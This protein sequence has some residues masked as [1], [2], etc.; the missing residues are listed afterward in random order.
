MADGETT[1]PCTSGEV[2][3]LRIERRQLAVRPASGHA[4]R[5]H[6]LLIVEERGVQRVAD[7]F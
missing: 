4:G 1:E 3:G 6:P 2:N 5:G 7:I